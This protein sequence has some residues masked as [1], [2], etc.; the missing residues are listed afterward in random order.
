MKIN[1]LIFYIWVYG[2]F[3]RELY[4]EVWPLIFLYHLHLVEVFCWKWTGWVWRLDR[5]HFLKPRIWVFGISAMSPIQVRFAI[6][7]KWILGW[8]TNFNFLLLPW[9]KRLGCKLLHWIV[10]KCFFCLDWL[11][12]CTILLVHWLLTH[13][14]SL[15]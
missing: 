15:W 10:A 3:Q 5:W 7:W 6:S 11:L 13:L 12:F 9:G 2:F 4:K 8:H 14:D 1:L